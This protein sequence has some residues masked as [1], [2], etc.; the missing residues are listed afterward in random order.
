VKENLE[1]MP[2]ANRGAYHQDKYEWLLM[3]FADLEANKPT[4]PT[5]Y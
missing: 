1:K 4:R 5:E 3:L 2:D